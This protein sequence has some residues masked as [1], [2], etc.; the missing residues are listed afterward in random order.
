MG[1][2]LDILVGFENYFIETSG[3]GGRWFEYSF[4]HLTFTII[5]VSQIPGLVH[6]E[7]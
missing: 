4:S 2:K 5:N 1:N 3:S 6:T 7:V